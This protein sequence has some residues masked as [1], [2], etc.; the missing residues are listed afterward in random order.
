ML[1]CNGK[2]WGYSSNPYF[3]RTQPISKKV[4][5]QFHAH[6]K[7]YNYD[8]GNQFE[9]QYVYPL[10]Q[11]Y[12]MQEYYS[13]NFTQNNEFSDNYYQASYPTYA[14]SKGISSKVNDTEEERK[15]FNINLEKILDKLDNRTTLMIKNIPN[16]YSQQ[17]LL[18]EIDENH[19][20]QYDFFYLP[21]DPQN[22]C[23]MGYAFIN[24]VVPIFIL[25]FY[26]KFNGHRWDK[27][28]SEKVT[29]I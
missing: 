9:N 1:S 3:L 6:T 8:Y 20:D 21:I 4:P 13:A 19:K 2:L 10:Y 22:Y 28:N 16:K 11:Y 14:F 15:K 29:R 24:F 23:N 18:A 5:M 26:E 12:P 17:M 25:K 7:S 27:F